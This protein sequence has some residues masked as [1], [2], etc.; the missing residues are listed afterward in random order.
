ME[1]RRGVATVTGANPPPPQSPLASPSDRKFAVLLRSIESDA[2]LVIR[3]KSARNAHKYYASSLAE[4]HYTLILLTL[5]REG[6]TGDVREITYPK[7]LLFIYRDALL[8]GMLRKELRVHWAVLEFLARK[9]EWRELIHTMQYL[10]RFMEADAAKA[11]RQHASNQMREQPTNAAVAQWAKTAEKMTKD[12]DVIISALKH[13]PSSSLP[14]S[15]PLLHFDKRIFHLVLIAESKLGRLDAMVHLIKV[16]IPRWERLI[17]LLPN[18]CSWTVGSPPLTRSDVHPSTPCFLLCAREAFAVGRFDV[19]RNMYLRAWEEMDS[20]YKVK[21]HTHT[22]SVLQSLL[23][24]SFI[25]PDLLSALDEPTWRTMQQQL[26]VLYLKGKDDV[27]LLSPFALPPVDASVATE[28]LREASLA[29]SSSSSSPPSSSSSSSSS[30]APPAAQLELRDLPSMLWVEKEDMWRFCYALSLLARQRHAEQ[31]HHA[32]AGGGEAGKSAAPVVYGN[33]EM[34]LT[35][36]IFDSLTSLS[37]RFLLLYLRS[38]LFLSR[39]FLGPAPSSVEELQHEIAM[40]PA[41]APLKGRKEE[42]GRGEEEVREILVQYPCATLELLSRL[43]SSLSASHTLLR[44]H[45]AVQ[46]AMEEANQDV[47]RRLVKEGKVEVV[48]QIKPI[49]QRPGAPSLPAPPPAPVKEE[50]YRYF[51]RFRMKTPLSPSAAST[52]LPLFTVTSL[53]PSLVLRRKGCMR[54]NVPSM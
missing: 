35:S 48:D 12:S 29:P 13:L 50:Y 8:K 46:Q 2:P 26:Y 1:L 27:E 37:L 54:V 52:P 24:S 23:P 22:G 19:A 28:L 20:D 18:S 21:I 5:L 38:P 47:V 53:P 9:E 43:L 11:I 42:R 44:L 36:P 4:E 10:R 16:E 31:K 33:L 51:Q 7:N 3:Q 39:W 25:V 40:D 14:S 30:S 49:P 17:T 6:S 45:F 32:H 41:P 34:E 15:S